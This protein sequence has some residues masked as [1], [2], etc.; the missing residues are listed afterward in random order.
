MFG[1]HLNIEEKNLCYEELRVQGKQIKLKLDTGAEANVI[2]LQ[3]LK[4]AGLTPLE[5]KSCKERLLNYSST[6]IR[7]VNL[8]LI[9]K[10]KRM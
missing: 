2:P 3:V 10:L 1:L 8:I 5:I 7:W 4:K 6:N 9:V